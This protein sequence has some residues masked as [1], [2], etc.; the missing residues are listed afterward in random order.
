MPRTQAE[1]DRENRRHEEEKDSIKERFKLEFE[2]ILKDE[3]ASAETILS[4][5]IMLEAI[6][7]I[8]IP[9]L[10]SPDPGTKVIL[11]L[12]AIG[13]ALIVAYWLIKTL[14]SNSSRRDTLKAWD[15][16]QAK[17]REEKRR[18]EEALSAP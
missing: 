12:L 8:I 7:T 4:I 15:E 16:R 17:L 2:L 6:V 10:L 18:H 9:L 13:V 14:I 5:T 11:A 1:I 3:G